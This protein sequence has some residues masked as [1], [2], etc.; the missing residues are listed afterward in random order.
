MPTPSSRL[1]SAQQRPGSLLRLTNILLG[2]RTGTSRRCDNNA[3][4]APPHGSCPNTHCIVVPR[5]VPTQAAYYERN[6][7]TQVNSAT[8]GLSAAAHPTLARGTWYAQQHVARGTKQP[9]DDQRVPH[10]N[11]F[12]L[13]QSWIKSANM[14]VEATPSSS[15]CYTPRAFRR[16]QHQHMVL[17]VP[18]SQKQETRCLLLTPSC[19]MY[20]CRAVLICFC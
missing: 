4:G 1:S 8:L 9:H 11:S 18:A 12:Y 13:S 15:S 19:S 2:Q 17:H 14:A 5:W 6:A 16:R 3:L 20:Q 7:W 10:D